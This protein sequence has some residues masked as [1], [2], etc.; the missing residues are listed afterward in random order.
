MSDSP[1]G[2]APDPSTGV[3]FIPLL[4][5]RRQRA[6]NLQK[7]QHAIPAAGLLAAGVQALLHREHGFALALAIGEVVFSVLLL[8]SLK[9]T[10]FSAR[11]SDHSGH[12]AHAGHGHG[13]DW[14]DIFAACVLTVEALEHW[15]THNHLPGPTLLTA[16]VTLG[17][18]LFHGRIAAHAARRRSLRIDAAGIRIRGRFFRRFFA[19]WHDIES[20][21]LDES[22]A[23]IVT[24]GGRQRRINL[25]D[26][27]NAPKVREALLTAQERWLA[28]GPPQAVARP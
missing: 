21:D 19:P 28:E 13:V 4:S 16:A 25:A 11:R 23:R 12:D 22:K 8:R 7:I 20:I 10:L 26:L 27:L 9:K 18:G 24:R 17:L 3:I 2:V 6:Q 5:R 1:E 15:H 14:F